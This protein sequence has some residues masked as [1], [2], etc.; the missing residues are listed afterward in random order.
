MEQIYKVGGY[1]PD[2]SHIQYEPFN[3]LKYSLNTNISDNIDLREFTSPLRNQ[4]K[5]SCCVAEAVTKALEIK[6]IIKY[7]KNKHIPLSILDNYYGARER[8]DPAQTN[9]DE[10]TYIYLSCNVLSDIGVCADDMWPFD[11]SKVFLKPPIMATREA[12]LNRIKTQYKILNDKNLR[13]DDIIFNLKSKNPVVFGTLVGQDWFE[14]DGK[15]TLGIETRPV[16]GHAICCVGFV[17]GKFI[18]ENSWGL[19]GDNGFAYL[20]PE[21]LI[22]ANDIWALVDGTEGW[23]EK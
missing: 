15:S 19:W 18:I 17:D 22:N 1:K 20:A 13:L 12:R 6:R 23:E 9:V 21:V 5:L 11:E 8:M 16:G 10:G 2:P 14:Y 3:K 7:G 4:G